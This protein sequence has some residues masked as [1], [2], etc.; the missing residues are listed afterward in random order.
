MST[1]GV[2]PAPRRHALAGEAGRL[3]REAQARYTEVDLL[4]VTLR[5]HVRDLQVE[6]ERL[7]DEIA[8][9][10][11]TARRESA[12]WMWRGQRPQAIAAR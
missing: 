7:L 12:V 6:R 2:V 4:V 1:G 9:L 5:D 10:R 11:D 8:R 3:R